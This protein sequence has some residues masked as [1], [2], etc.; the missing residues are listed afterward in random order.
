MSGSFS[1]EGHCLAFQP[2][3]LSKLFALSPAT[4]H[5]LPVNG[6]GK[7]SDSLVVDSFHSPC[8]AYHVHTGLRINSREESAFNLIF[9]IT[10]MIIYI[11]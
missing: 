6:D 2:L 11:L 5:P 3:P 9:H 10:L 8:L 4:L 1:G 7:G